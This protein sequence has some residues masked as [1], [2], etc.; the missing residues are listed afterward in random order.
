MFKVGRMKLSIVIPDE[1]AEPLRNAAR[2]AGY[3]SVSEW[4]RN[5]MAESANVER[6]P[7][8]WGGKRQAPQDEHVEQDA[9]V[10]PPKPDKELRVVLTP[11]TN[12]A[13]SP[14]ELLRERK[15]QAAV[16]F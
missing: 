4:L 5:F 12:G 9:A 1:W 10:A 14:A 6:A 8:S 16:K 7:K 11:S 3:K 2:A 13:K 15:A